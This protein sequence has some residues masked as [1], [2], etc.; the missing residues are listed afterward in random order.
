MSKRGRLWKKGESKW[1]VNEEYIKGGVHIKE[2]NKIPKRETKNKGKHIYRGRANK[3]EIQ[4]SRGTGRYN[5][6]EV[7]SLFFKHF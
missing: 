3:R 5:N 4:R 1:R 7:Y 6:F 2:E